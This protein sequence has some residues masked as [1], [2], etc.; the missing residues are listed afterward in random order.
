MPKDWL[1]ER[2]SNPLSY[3]QAK[4]TSVCCVQGLIRLTGRTGQLA[5]QADADPLYSFSPPETAD[6]SDLDIFDTSLS[7]IGQKEKNVAL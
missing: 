4:L 2:V 5:S 6:T 1:I 3:I 7:S